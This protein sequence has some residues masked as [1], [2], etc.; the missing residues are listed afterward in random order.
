MSRTKKISRTYVHNALVVGRKEKIMNHNS[1]NRLLAF[2]FILGTA[3]CGSAPP[4]TFQKRQLVCPENGF[5]VKYSQDI[6]YYGAFRRDQKEL[7]FK[8]HRDHWSP[9]ALFIGGGGE[10]V[11]CLMTDEQTD[12]LSFS[13]TCSEDR[14][15]GPY[16]SP[17]EYL[18]LGKEFLA[19]LQNEPPAS[20]RE[21]E[22]KELLRM[23][24]NFVTTF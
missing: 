7:Q 1:L 4:P 19:F 3:S 18:D 14:L 5:C 20:E 24:H 22:H 8:I 6:Y 10:L 2:A 16:K 11:S 12:I 13:L 23:L 15:H 9:T 17:Q 21:P